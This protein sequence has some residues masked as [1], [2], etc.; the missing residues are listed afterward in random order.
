MKIKNIFQLFQINWKSERP[1]GW[2]KKLEKRCALKLLQHPGKAH[3]RPMV[4]FDLMRFRS[5]FDLI[6]G[7]FPLRNDSQEKQQNQAKRLKLDSLNKHLLGKHGTIRSVVVFP[8]W[9]LPSLERLSS[10]CPQQMLHLHQRFPQI[11]GWKNMKNQIFQTPPPIAETTTSTSVIDLP[12]YN[13]DISQWSQRA[14]LVKREAGFQC[15]NVLEYWRSIHPVRF[16]KGRW[17][18]MDPMLWWKLL[19]IC[20]TDGFVGFISGNVGISFSTKR[21]MDFL[22]TT[23][24]KIGVLGPG[25]LGFLGVS[26]K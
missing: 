14:C 22:G 25:G 7:E 15:P 26:L 24:G 8:P 18:E 4:F 13:S 9:T 3:Q 16:L 20:W 1:G 11:S 5:F 17:H 6:I 23:D 10:I 12:T 19:M 21:N 2:E